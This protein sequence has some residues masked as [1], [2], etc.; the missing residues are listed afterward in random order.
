MDLAF[1]G[2]ESCC[3]LSAGEAL[4]EIPV[5]DSGGLS[6]SAVLTA[7]LTAIVPHGALPAVEID[8][9]DTLQAPV[10]AGDPIGEAR[11]IVQGE[12]VCTVPLIAAVGVAR[13]D[14]PAR[15]HAVW[16]HWLAVP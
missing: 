2:W 6:V 13:D 15:W 3:L 16:R 5:A 1:A 7:D 12:T 14:Y 10:A 4:R 8:L 9:P 11:M